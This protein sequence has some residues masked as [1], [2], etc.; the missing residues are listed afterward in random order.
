MGKD[1]DSY[2]FL[3][4]ASRKVMKAWAAREQPRPIPW[5][6]LTKPLSESK[7][8][9]LSSA[10]IALDDDAPFDQEGERRNPWW[11]D[12]THRVI[13]RGTTEGEVGVYHLHIDV[14]PA[15][16]DLDCVLPL[17]RLDELVEAGVVGAAADSHYSMMGY[18]LDPREL[19]EETTPK[20]IARLHQE[21][22]HA[23]LLA[24]V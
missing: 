19:L 5:T 24:P 10:G 3:D 12:P 8:A 23:L 18:I 14:R 20:M 11:G 9:L 13:P 6:A 22:V 1:E 2:R 15:Q 4:F 7:V 21:E 16:Q 17:R